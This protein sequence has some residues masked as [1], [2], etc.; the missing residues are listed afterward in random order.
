MGLLTLRIELTACLRW[1]HSLG[2]LPPPW[3]EQRGPP[4]LGK[5]LAALETNLPFLSRRRWLISPQRWLAI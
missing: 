2:F 1:P 3:I 4:A 5:R